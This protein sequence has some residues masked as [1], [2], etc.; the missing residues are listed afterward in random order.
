MITVDHSW[1]GVSRMT[2]LMVTQYVNSHL[3]PERFLQ[4]WVVCEF[5]FWKLFKRLV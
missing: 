1:E 4:I 5:I 2:I 3:L